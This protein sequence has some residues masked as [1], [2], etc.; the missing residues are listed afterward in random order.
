M[1]LH[2]IARYAGR[3]L[4]M[5]ESAARDLAWRAL[6]WDPRALQHARLARAPGQFLSRLGIANM[7]SLQPQA[8][9]DEEI[10]E[11]PPPRPIGYAPKYAPEPEFEGFGW[12]LVDGIACLDIEGALLDRGFMTISGAPFWGYDTIGQALKEAAAEPRV[13]GIFVR[14]NSP[15]GVVAGTLEALTADIRALRQT[16]NANGKPV[17]VFADCAAS[18]AY[19]I[20]AQ[21]DR[22]FAPA[23]GM[24]GS[25][26]AVIVH[27]DY[28]GALEKAGI[29]VESIQFGR[30]KTDGASW[31]PLSE[32][33]RADLQAE[34]DA[35]GDR[36]IAD[37]T[38]G[39]EFLTRNAQLA[40]EAA[41]YMAAHEDPSRSGLALKLVDEIAHEEA[42]FAALLAHVR[43]QPIKTSPLS[44]SRGAPAPAAADS[45][46][47]KSGAQTETE[48]MRKSKDERIAAVMS[49]QAMDDSEKLDAIR[50]ILDEEEEK[51]EGDEE[52]TT[53]EG[54]EEDETTA[55][56]EQEEPE[57]AE[58]DEEEEEED[59][60]S[61]KKAR[62]VGRAIM[63]LPEAKGREQLAAELAFTPR[64]SVAAAKRILGAAPKQSRLVGQVH[65][66]KLGPSGEAMPAATSEAEKASNFVLQCMAAARAQSPA[67]A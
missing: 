40:T 19:W 48:N 5:T 18:A 11:R 14:M 26:G 24:V 54:E 65:D 67:K 33:A 36:F 28:S 13:K 53:A 42:A 23:V 55:Q 27:E 60:G 46:D 12:A 9:E 47:T 22:I 29:R 32:E 38:A 15:G 34:I 58:G 1:S 37:V 8:M 45:N 17:Y 63:A 20:S 49:R 57:A 6:K 31:K 51:A 30:K 16:G 44:A 66:P 7:F 4:L 41:C 2:R 43:G 25:I 3:P 50:K 39:R 10:G 35:I 61:A 62:A 56:D 21:A 64:M 59:E 52:E